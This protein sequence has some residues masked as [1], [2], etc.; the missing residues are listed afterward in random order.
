MNRGKPIIISAVAVALLTATVAWIR[1]DA[2]GLV[3]GAPDLK[4]IGQLAFGPGNVLFVGD[5]D[6]AQIH[7]IELSDAVS[8]TGPIELAG[9]D[10]KVAQV[11]GV[12]PA[13]LVI[14][15]MA[16]H[17]TSRNVFLSV[18]RG[19][20]TDAHPV[21]LKVT[22]NAAR[23]IEE[24]SLANVKY[25]T[26]AI[27]NPPADNPSARRNPRAQTITDLAFVDGQVWVAGLSSEQFASAF[28]QIAYPFTKNPGTTTLEIYHVSHRASET[29]SP[30]TT[31]VPM[32]ISGKPY[33]VAGYTCTPIVAFDAA[34]LKPGQH[35]VGRTVAE[36]GAGNT[37]TDL[38][39][40]TRDGK[41]VI[42]VVNSRRP[43]MLLDA[44]E[45]A[46]GPALTTPDNDGIARTTIAQPAGITQMSDL[47]AQHV[48]VI[49]RGQSGLDLRSI[50]K[51]TL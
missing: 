21:L 51:S 1:P 20:G 32:R 11:L 22:R 30:I 9:I 28:R 26:A 43:L 2:S 35:V 13:D 39:A 6:G 45:V 50:A 31:F 34:S 10:A 36:L 33:I 16:V 47:D 19:R 8:G 37:P 25:A 44:N 27:T 49:Q 42:L 46:S 5:N 29:R 48:V 38:V 17:P 15:D 7:A 23:P 40:F 18:T 24:V 41:E 3:R 12:T 14:N 4:S